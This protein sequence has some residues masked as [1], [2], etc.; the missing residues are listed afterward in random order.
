MLQALRVQVLTTLGNVDL[1]PCI[2]LHSVAAALEVWP[3]ALVPPQPSTPSDH[4]TSDHGDAILQ[5][6]GLVGM[7][8]HAKL[9]ILCQRLGQPSST[10]TSADLSQSGTAP[11]LVLAQDDSP[12]M[13][14]RKL[15]LAWGQSILTH[16]AAQAVRDVL[17]IHWQQQHL[18]SAQQADPGRLSREATAP[19]CAAAAEKVL[20][21]LRHLGTTEEGDVAL[22]DDRWVNLGL[23]LQLI[24]SCL[25]WEWA[26]EQVSCLVLEAAV[27]AQVA[28]CLCHSMRSAQAGCGLV[29]LVQ[30][31]FCCVLYGEEP[32][33]G[34]IS[35]C[36]SC[37]CLALLRHWNSAGSEDTQRPAAQLNELLDTACSK[38]HHTLCHEV[39][40]IACFGSSRC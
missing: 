11:G 8:V 35:C 2:Q 17:S 22:L 21:E 37:C 23:A 36:E 5:H 31:L 25:G 10:S 4:S 1:A 19:L 28:L 39:V 20:A 13:T 15:L 24:I 3:E 27:P 32:E 34:Q 6:Q 26:Y 40:L 38:L 30:A 29:C 7:C 9:Q 16:T 12:S 18:E 14:G 33:G